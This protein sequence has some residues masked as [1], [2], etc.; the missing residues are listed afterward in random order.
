MKSR[1]TYFHNL[2][3]LFREKGKCKARYC[4]EKNGTDPADRGSD[5]CKPGTA[6]FMPIAASALNSW[7]VYYE[8]VTT[9]DLFN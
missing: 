6:A 9:T 7:S 3:A 4:D 1:I 8:Q 5:A 2:R